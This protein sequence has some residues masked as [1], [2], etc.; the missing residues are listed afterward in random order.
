MLPSHRVFAGLLCMTA[1][2][3]Y[4]VQPEKMRLA[5]SFER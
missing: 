1:H 4:A 5:S 3:A 2:Q